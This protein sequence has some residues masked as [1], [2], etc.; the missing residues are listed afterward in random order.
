MAAATLETLRN[1][2]ASL[3]VTRCRMLHERVRIENGSVLRVSRGEPEP[4]LVRIG[5]CSPEVR[6]RNLACGHTM[7][8]YA[9]LDAVD[10]LHAAGWLSAAEHASL[11]QALESV[12]N[13]IH[14][15]DHRKGD[16]E[17]D[18]ALSS[19]KKH[20]SCEESA[21]EVGRLEEQHDAHAEQVRELRS[22]VLAHL[23]AAVRHDDAHAR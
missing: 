2:I 21:A 10:A 9:L 3:Q 17:R 18:L 11:R 1:Q 19:E 22:A 12:S 7:A 13:A 20:L 6:A 14:L 5:L 16:A 4:G 8:R 15:L 23:D